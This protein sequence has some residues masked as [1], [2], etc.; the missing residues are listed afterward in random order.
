MN[1]SKVGRIARKTFSTRPAS[2]LNDTHMLL[3]HMQLV[4]SFCSVH[5]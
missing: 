1:A 3:I 5:L 2:T 4:C